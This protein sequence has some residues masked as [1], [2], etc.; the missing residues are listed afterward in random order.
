MT[1]GKKKL[2]PAKQTMKKWDKKLRKK[3]GGEEKKVKREFEC[4]L[5]DVKFESRR[6]LKS[7]KLQKHGIECSIC[8]EIFA[9]EKGLKTHLIRKHNILPEGVKELHCKKCGKGFPTYEELTKH[10]IVQHKKTKRQYTCPSCQDIFPSLKTLIDHDIKKCK[11]Q[12]IDEFTWPKGRKKNK[13]LDIIKIQEK[14][15][16][17]IV[18]CDLHEHF[19]DEAIDLVKSAML[20]CQIDG[21][22]KLE[23]IH[24][25]RRGT[26]LREYFRSV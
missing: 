16:E 19:L 5:C 20:K 22:K 15:E 26:I 4:I 8:K 12:R 25:Y 23:I 10:K 7:H 9:S 1:R 6:K 11:Q 17:L 14:K 3:N 13:K 18:T 24:G 21:I 2:S